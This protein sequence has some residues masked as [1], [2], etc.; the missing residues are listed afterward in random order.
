MGAP[1][2]HMRPLLAMHTGQGEDEA[3]PF[4]L[5]SLLPLHPSHRPQSPALRPSFLAVCAECRHRESPCSNAVASFICCFLPPFCWQNQ[6][7]EEEDGG[8]K[9]GGRR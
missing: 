3:G 5:A 2:L 4:L 8:C 6:M 1:L 9:E 7:E